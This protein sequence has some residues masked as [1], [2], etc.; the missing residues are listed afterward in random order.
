VCD[1]V[2]RVSDAQSV[3]PLTVDLWSTSMVFLAGHRIRVDVANSSFPRW[4]RPPA[5]NATPS[6]SP[7]AAQVFVDGRRPSFVVLPVRG[8]W[9]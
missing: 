6:Y 5:R 7:T 9:T 2:V 8:P 3:D 4:D 1:G